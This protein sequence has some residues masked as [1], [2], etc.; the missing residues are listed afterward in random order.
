MHFLLTYL[1]HPVT[2]K[3]FLLVLFMFAFKLSLDCMIYLTINH[4]Y[5]PDL[6]H[7]DKAPYFSRCKRVLFNV[8]EIKKKTKSVLSTGWKTSGSSLF[9]AQ[10]FTHDIQSV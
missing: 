5:P 10:K 2:T 6:S 3:V 4:T 7:F 9:L 8:H 1:Y